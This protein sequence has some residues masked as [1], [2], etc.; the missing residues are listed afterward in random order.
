MGNVDR[1]SNKSEKNKSDREGPVF[2]VAVDFSHCSRLALKKAKDLLENWGG[3]I[4]VFHVIDH[5]FVEQCVQCQLGKKGEIKKKLFVGAKARLQEF[6]RKEGLE[7][8][9]VEKVVCEGSPCLEINKK[10]AEIDAEM[11]VIGS[12]GK[13]ED[14]KSIFFGSTAERVLRFIMRPVLCVPPDI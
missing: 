10:A 2:L 6:V 9:R 11:I 4:V 12:Q 1:E 14:M 7:G 13:S 3:R 5:D 8:D